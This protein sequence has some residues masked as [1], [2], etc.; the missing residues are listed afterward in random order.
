[1]ASLSGNVKFLMGHFRNKKNMLIRTYK[2]VIPN[3]KASIVL[4]HGNRC[5]FR[6]EFCA[7]NMKWHMETH[8]VGTPEIDDIVKAELDAVYP[9]NAGKLKVT[10]NSEFPNAFALDGKNFFDISPR[11]IYEG[12][13]IEKMN[14]LGFDVYGLDLQSSGL[15]EGLNGR[16]NFFRCLDD[17][18]EDVIQFVDIVKRG[19]FDDLEE[20]YDKEKMGKASTIGKVYLAGISMGGSI[21]LRFA[22]LTS[23]YKKDGQNFIDGLIA[24]APMTDLSIYTKG[25]FRKIQLCI[26]RIIAAINPA[27]TFLLDED[28]SIRTLNAFFRGN[29]PHYFKTTQCYAVV[30][31]LF[32]ATTKLSRDYHLYPK[33]M[34][35]IIL[36]TSNDDV[37]TVKGSRTVANVHLKDHKDFKLVELDGNAHCITSSLFL[38]NIMP[39]VTE[40]LKRVHS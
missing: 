10:G 9:K 36:H 11:F 25:L 1:M 23:V 20:T 32:E 2:A 3:P 6:A 35:T 19:K 5:H 34:P 39:H 28:L 31:S 30:W 26:A 12:S 40:W 38:D 4:V 15:S 7:H 14:E 29:D 8:R 22:Q 17:L 21:V 16:R 37:C 33:D 27:C 18:V 13:F 24:F